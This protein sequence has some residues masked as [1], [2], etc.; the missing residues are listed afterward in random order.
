MNHFLSKKIPWGILSGLFGI[1][2]FYVTLVVVALYI[3]LGKVAAQT[4]Q[5]A[6]LF[7]TWYQTLLFILDILFGVLFLASLVFYILKKGKEHKKEDP[8]APTEKGST[9]ETL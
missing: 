7:G 5:A 6:S 3:I 8:T 2:F 4:T 1:L 9:D